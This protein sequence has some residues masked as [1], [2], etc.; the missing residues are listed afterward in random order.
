MDACN[1]CLFLNYVCSLVKASEQSPEL[2]TSHLKQK[3]ERN[4]KPNFNN[5]DIIKE[6]AHIDESK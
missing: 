4:S 3:L 1:K 5:N 2:S 6:Q